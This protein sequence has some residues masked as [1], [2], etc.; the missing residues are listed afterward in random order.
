MGIHIVQLQTE[1]AVCMSPAFPVACCCCCR[2]CCVASVVS[3]SLRPRRWQPTRFPHPW[4]SPGKNTG[5][6]CH[7]LL[8]CMK[9][10]SE[11]EVAQSYP[12]LAIPWTAAYQAPPSMGFSRQKCWS[13][14]PLPSVACLSC[15]FLAAFGPQ[16]Q[17]EETA[18]RMQ[19]AVRG[20]GRTPGAAL[21]GGARQDG[22]MSVGDS[23]VTEDTEGQRGAQV[24]T[25]SMGCKGLCTPED[26]FPYFFFHKYFKLCGPF[27]LARTTQLHQCRAKT[28]TDNT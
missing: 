23:P 14:V 7:F 2:C 27:G 21:G 24:A 9:V 10:K 6:G 15:Y 22:T 3:D 8:Q 20:W 26:S 17:E 4:D 11:S 1:I 28:A 13:G 16:H 12:T 25:H 19:V 18:E 5:V